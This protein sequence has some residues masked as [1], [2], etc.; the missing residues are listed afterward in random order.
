MS[1]PS[2][3]WTSA[4]IFIPVFTPRP[5]DHGPHP[6]ELAD[7]VGH[8]PGHG[9]DHAGDHRPRHIPNVRLIQ[10]EH[11]QQVNGNLIPGFILIGL[12]GTPEL[13]H[14]SGVYRPMV[15]VVLPM[16]TVRIILVPPVR[17]MS[18]AGIHYKGCGR[19]N[20]CPSGGMCSG[21]VVGFF[22][23]AVGTGGNGA[24]RAGPYFF[25]EIGERTPRGRR[26]LPLG[27]PFSGGRNGGRWLV[28]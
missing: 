26:F 25:E 8:G 1:A 3:L 22:P 11:V 7:G 18:L 27:T 13:E 5:H 23:G 6:A 17:S 28:R 14:A 15:M 4:R 24:S 12:D 20:Q 21:G 10:L 9:R 16:S 19:K 2:W